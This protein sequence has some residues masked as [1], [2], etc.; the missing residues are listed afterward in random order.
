MKQN[1]KN[2][3]DL[4]DKGLKVRWDKIKENADS[5]VFVEG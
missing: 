5:T 1:K 4:Y 3:G 2:T